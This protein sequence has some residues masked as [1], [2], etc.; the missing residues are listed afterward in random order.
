VTAD[1]AA[2]RIL[3]DPHATAT[4]RQ[5]RLEALARAVLSVIDGRV[6]C[7]E[8]GSMGPHDH[9]G[10]RREPCYCCAACGL[11]FEAPEVRA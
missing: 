7:P 11:H 4:E 1:Q 3:L 9:N 2:I 6:E 8:C 5:E 10:D